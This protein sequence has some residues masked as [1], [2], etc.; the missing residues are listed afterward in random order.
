MSRPLRIYCSDFKHYICKFGKPHDILNELISA[1]FCEI[2]KIRIPEYRL[3]KLVPEHVPSGLNRRQYN[4]VGIGSEYLDHALELSEFLLTWDGNTYDTG[5]ILNKEDFIRIGLFD[6]W[7]S[8][9]DRNHNNSNLLIQPTNEG[10]YFVAIDHV[11]I[12]NTN[13]LDKG[14]V[15]L[16]E[17]SSILFSQYMSLLFKNPEKL[18][19]AMIDIEGSYFEMVSK[20]RTSLKTIMAEVP[21]EWGIDVQKQIIQMEQLFSEDWMREVLTN[22]R[23]YIAR[24]F[25]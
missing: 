22:F 8:N 15:C 17:D 3:I 19:A 23:L 21:S 4:R 11:N 18:S 9:E 10:F 7:I 20:C 5:R 12:F 24:N 1:R 25:A 2:W 13:T 14:L 16:T 6:L